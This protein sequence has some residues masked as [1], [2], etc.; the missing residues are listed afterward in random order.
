MIDMG[1]GDEYMLKP[2][3]LSWRQV[4]NITKVEENSFFFEECFNV[5]RRVSC[6][7]VY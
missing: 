2:V 4:C 5:E 3:Y 6:S 1:V 7:P